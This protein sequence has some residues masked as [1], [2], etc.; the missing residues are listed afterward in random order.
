VSSGATPQ[1]PDPGTEQTVRPPD[2]TPAA[3]AAPPDVLPRTFAEANTS[4]GVLAKIQRV[5]IWLGPWHD[6]IVAV[7]NAATVAADALGHPPGASGEE[8]STLDSAITALDNTITAANHLASQWCPSA[9]AYWL[10][11]NDGGESAVDAVGPH[12]EL[13]A[14]ALTNAD[15]AWPHVKVP[16]HPAGGSAEWPRNPSETADVALTVGNALEEASRHAALLLLVERSTKARVGERVDV[17]AALAEW[18]LPAEDA[19]KLLAWIVQDPPKFDGQPV[20]LVVDTT[21]GSLYRTASGRWEETYT[22]TAALWGTILA[23]ALVIAVFALLR[24]A[25]ITKWPTDWFPKM[26]VL[27]LCVVGGA[28]AHVASKALANINFDDP[29]RIYAASRG[30][31]WL[32][33]RWLSILCLL[34]PIVVVTGSL[35]GAGNIPT[36]FQDIG[37]AVLSGYS[38]DSLF[39]NSIARL[40]STNS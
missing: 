3:A 15:V 5:S 29:L 24:A 27:Y 32:R 30:L 20:P 17:A 34:V 19:S 18:D 37:V 11:G 23:L 36:H 7:R 35:W 39:R 13:L 10:M 40:S 2:A 33:L 25:H 22:T 38:A 26:V 4:T 9:A 12:S 8:G 14:I 16:R 28:A 1:D 21:S 31:D 6:A